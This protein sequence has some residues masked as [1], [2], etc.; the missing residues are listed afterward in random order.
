MVFNVIMRGLAVPKDSNLNYCR[1]VTNTNSRICNFKNCF[2]VRISREEKIKKS[3]LQSD[4]HFTQ[5]A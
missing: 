4:F 2:I 1:K 5:S 3:R